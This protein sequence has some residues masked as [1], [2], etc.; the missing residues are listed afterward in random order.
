MMVIFTRLHVCINK[1]RFVVVE[2]TGKT[3]RKFNKTRIE[4]EWDVVEEQYT[5]THGWKKRDNGGLRCDIT[6]MSKKEVMQL[7]FCSYII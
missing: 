3:L 2:A 6:S 7:F 5:H 4:D 1:L